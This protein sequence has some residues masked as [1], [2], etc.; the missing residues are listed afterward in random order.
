MSFSSRSA[1]AASSCL[2]LRHAVRTSGRFIAGDL[3]EVEDE[4]WDRAHAVRRVRVGEPVADM[5][6]FP[7]G[8]DRRRLRDRSVVV[9]GSIA[10][11]R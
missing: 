3:A 7:N 10:D 8:R 1:R 4:R 11:A 5:E 6:Q 2:Q 9:D